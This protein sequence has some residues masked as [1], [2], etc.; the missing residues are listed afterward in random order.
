MKQKIAPSQISAN[1]LL[2]DAYFNLSNTPKSELDSV[3]ILEVWVKPGT[4]KDLPHGGLLILVEDCLVGAFMDG[5]PYTH[6]EYPYT[7]IE[8]L[9]NDTFFADS[10]L[11]DLIELQKEYNETRTQIGLAAK[12]M[13]NPQLLAQQNSIIPGRVTNEPGQIIQY[14]PGTPPP[15]PIPLQPLPDYVVRMQ[16]TILMDIEDISGQHEVSKG[17]TPAGVSAGTAL[18]FLKETDDNYLTPQ[19]QNVEDAFERIARQTMTLLQQIVDSGST[20]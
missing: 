6:G 17:Q 2:D 16:E 20:L 1:G 9:S 12:R 10:P 13:G 18:A 5:M 11:V 14:R 4:H 7:K 19:Y 15:S 8:H 3:V